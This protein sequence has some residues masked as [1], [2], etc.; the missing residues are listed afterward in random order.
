MFK[1]S[2]SKAECLIGS[3]VLLAMTTV[4]MPNIF[5]AFANKRKAKA[6]NN[7]KMLGICL[8]EFDNQYGEFPSDLTAEVI[9]EE[10]E[11]L[12]KGKTA[13]HYLAQLLATKIID[14]EKIFYVDGL[15]GIKKADEIFN[16]PEA[17]LARGENGFG[18]VMLSDGTA[19]SQSY[20][21]SLIP[22]LVTPVLKGGKMPTLQKKPFHGKGI[23][24][25]LDSSVGAY[26]IGKNN[27]L[28]SPKFN[29]NVFLNGEGT[30]WGV[31]APLLREPW[32]LEEKKV[33]A[34]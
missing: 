19:L 16:T 30:I 17:T 25:R 21:S 7:A 23:V 14:T 24:L 33:E 28:L 8:T 26:K 34:K 4:A 20:G 11:K 12:P 22:V 5:S 29:Q 13:N 32:L 31:D 10:G 27:E 2:L 3:I 9:I 6:I 18:Y 1:S 15:A